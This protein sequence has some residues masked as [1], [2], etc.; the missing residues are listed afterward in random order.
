M[1]KVGAIDDNS[2]DVLQKTFKRTNNSTIPLY[3][4]IDCSE[5]KEMRKF[6]PFV[7]VSHNGKVFIFANLQLCG[8][9]RNVKECPLIAYL[10]SDQSSHI[11]QALE[12]YHC[13]LNLAVSKF[14]LC[15]QSLRIFK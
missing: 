7:E 11:L 14:L 10:G 12:L 13:K 4:K 3:V 6:S 1:Q 9:S 2:S 8:F 5:K 15:Q